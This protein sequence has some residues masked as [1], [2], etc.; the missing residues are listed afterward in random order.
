M[1][2][3]AKGLRVAIDTT[4]A[5]KTQRSGV[6]HYVQHLVHAMADVALSDDRFVLCYRLSRWGRREHRLPLPE[7]GRFKQRWMQ[8]GL[9]PIGPARRARARRPAVRVRGRGR[10]VTIH[11]VFALEDGAEGT[12]EWRAR[13]AERY[14][15]VADRADLI[16]C[17]SAWTRNRFLNHFPEVG[18]EA[19][20]GRAAR[21]LPGVL[22]PR[23]ARTCRR[24]GARSTS[25]A[26]TRSS[27]AC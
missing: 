7:R 15:V 6:A 20:A 5:M 16:L 18:R 11:D 9:H 1:A 26:P 23:P 22:V 14:Q 27:S 4:P 10:V 24:C 8:G 17:V 21:R 25:R 13:M 2:K 12:A 3:A 19:G